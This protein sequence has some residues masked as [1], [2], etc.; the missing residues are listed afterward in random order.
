MVKQRNDEA[1]LLSDEILRNFELSELPSQNI[2]LKC[3][4]LA[5]LL[6]DFEGVEWLRQEVNGFDSDSEGLLTPAAWAATEKSGRRYFIDDPDSK[7]QNPKPKKVEQAFTQSIAAMEASVSSGRARMD[8]AF[9][10][11]V[12]LSSISQFAAPQGNAAERSGIQQQ[13]QTSIE[14]IEKVKARLYQYVLNLNYELSFSELTEDIFSR[15]RLSVDTALKDIYPEAVQK[16]ISVYENLK[17]DDDEN[18]ANAVLTCRRII[19]EVADSLFPPLAE[20]I[21]VSGKLIKVGEDQYINRLIQYIES[22]SSCGKIKSDVGSYLKFISETLDNV[23]EAANKGAH[24]E[25]T[26]QEAERYII[27][28]YLVIGD[29]LSL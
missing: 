15:M 16:F 6:N 1:L 12:S 7:A 25:V 21:E 17:S 3:L 2:L 14:R 11:N 18:W 22:K 8:V 29:V 5:R 19:K 10:R 27:Y 13:I 20:P 24:T 9:D 23:H 4:R 26:L 28:T